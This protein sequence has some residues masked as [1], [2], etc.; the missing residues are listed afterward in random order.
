MKLEIKG[1]GLIVSVAEKGQALEE[2][3]NHPFGDIPLGGRIG[4]A[5]SNSISNF[6]NLKVSGPEIMEM[7]VDPENRLLATWAAIKSAY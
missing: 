4:F 6:D 5:V 1:G 7:S 2:K 3:A